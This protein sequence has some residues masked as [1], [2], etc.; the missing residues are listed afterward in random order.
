MYLDSVFGVAVQGQA[1]DILVKVGLP[2][3]FRRL[4]TMVSLKGGKIVTQ[5]MINEWIASTLPSYLQS[6]YEERGDV[7][8]AFQ[9]DMGIRF[10]VNIFRQSGVQGFVARVLESHIRTIDELQLPRIL[11]K[12][13]RYNGG[14]VFIT[15]TTG[16]GKSTTLAA[17][18]Q[19]I[20]LK[21]SFHV[22]TLEDPIEYVFEDQKSLFNQREIGVDTLS[23]D[24]GLKG[25]LRQNPDVIMIGEL[26][27]EE[28]A[29]NALT[30]AETGIL[31]LTTLHTHNAVESLN[32]FLSFFPISEHAVIADFLARNLRLSLSQRLIKTVDGKSRVVAT[33][34]MVV[35]Q[36][37][38]EI[39]QMA[40]DYDNLHD[41]IKQSN[42]FYY[43]HSF[44]Q[45]LI[46]LYREGRITEASALRFANSPSDLK[47]AISGV[48]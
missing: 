32:R 28:T 43:M 18:M 46:A 48:A 6:T 1:S 29:K 2:V 38:R 45:S 19:N 5:K 41:I 16:S 35:N 22:I 36:R 40:K 42:D 14:I 34:V 24:Q 15:G 47:V 20:N 21:Y 39:I 3:R 27:D 26:R 23:F 7:D 10:R 25:A 33:E 4:G 30:A 13:P 17:I 31:V 8:F 37:I 9:D 44:D 12:V 11:H